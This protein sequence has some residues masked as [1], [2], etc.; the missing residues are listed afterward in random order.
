[1]INDSCEKAKHTVGGVTPGQVLLG[2]IRKYIEEAMRGHP[3]SG[4]LL[5]LLRQLLPS[6]F[7]SQY[8][9]EL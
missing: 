2:S 6:G 9:V 7:C 5:L 3:V 1:M 8:D 4:I